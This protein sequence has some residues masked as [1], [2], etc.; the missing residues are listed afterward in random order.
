MNDPLLELVSI[1]TDTHPLDGIFYRPA[2][3]APKACAMICHG[4]CM[5]FYT[6]ASRFLPPVLARRGIACLTFN[7]RGHD[8]LATLNGRELVGGGVQRID[9]GIADNVFAAGW[10]AGRGFPAPIVIG[11]SNGGMLAAR[12][13]ADHPATPALVL[14]SAHAGGTAMMELASRHG[15]LAGDR[16]DAVTAEARERMAA[17][18][19]DDLMLLPGWWY[20]ITPASFLDYRERLPD[21]LAQ[22]ERIRCPSLY[23]RGSLEPAD[24]YPAEA[25]AE[26]TG[27]RGKAIVVEGSDHFYTGMEAAVADLVA[28]WLGDMLAA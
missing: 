12:H 24:L 21:T 2:T 13:C 10:L 8:I 26:R 7:R 6:G 28:D 15:L 5:N 14:M 25:F 16:L 3:A 20:A 4:N 23:L 22:A 19:G 27:G 17:G 1:E 9:E 18:R 11:H